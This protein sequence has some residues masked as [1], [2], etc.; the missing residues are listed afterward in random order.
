MTHGSILIG[1]PGWLVP[2]CLLTGSFTV[3]DI[4]KGYLAFFFYIQQVTQHDLQVFLLL[5]QFRPLFANSDNKLFKLFLIATRRTI[6][7]DHVCRFIQRQSQA[8]ATQD[9]PQ[10]GA[11]C[12]GVNTACSVA[13]G[14]Q[15]AFFFLKADG[16]GGD[17]EFTRKVTDGI[18]L[19]H[20]LSHVDFLP[21]LTADMHDRCVQK[22]PQDNT[23]RLR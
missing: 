3:H 8:F 16:A 19:F 12:R 22:S 11:V 1:L 2:E 23:L 9:Q 18:C 20:L 7:L 17:I 5:L 14:S 4:G 10:T 21:S 15:V 13:F 6:H